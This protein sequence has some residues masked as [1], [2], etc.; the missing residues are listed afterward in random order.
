[1]RSSL[2]VLYKKKKFVCGKKKGHINVHC[3][4]FSNGEVTKRFAKCPEVSRGR[5]G[6]VLKKCSFARS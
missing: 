2:N 6:A 3:K 5:K 4:Y 1:M